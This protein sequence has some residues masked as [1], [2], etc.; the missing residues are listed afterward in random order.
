M[1]FRASTICTFLFLMLDYD[2]LSGQTYYG[3]GAGLDCI[4]LHEVNVTQSDY[5]CELTLLSNNADCDISWVT[6]DELGSFYVLSNAPPSI[7]SVSLPSG[8][9]SPLYILD[10]TL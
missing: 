9:N 3:L 6:F 5:E 1:S 2:H 8:Q 4:K 10:P 7:L